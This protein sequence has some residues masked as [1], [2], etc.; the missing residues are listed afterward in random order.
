[1]V[2]IV[3]NKEANDKKEVGK[4]HY[5][6]LKYSSEEGSAMMVLASE[7]KQVNGITVIEVPN[8]E[9]QQNAT[10]ILIDNGFS[11]FAMMSSICRTA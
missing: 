2:T 9:G 6:D 4:N 11:G 5:K 10:T 1:M 7:N 3:E 8:K